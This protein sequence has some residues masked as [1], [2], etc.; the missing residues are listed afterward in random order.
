[1]ATCHIEILPCATKKERIEE[2]AEKAKTQ[3]QKNAT[4]FEKVVPWEF[5]RCQY[6]PEIIHLIASTEDI[7]CGWAV[8]RP[9][10]TAGYSILELDTITTRRKRMGEQRLGKLMFD[11]I[12]DLFQKGGYDF[13][14][15]HGI[16][17]AVLN[18]YKSWGFAPL[19][20]KEDLSFAPTSPPLLKPFLRHL[21][22]YPAS[23]EVKKTFKDK[24][25]D[26]G[27]ELIQNGYLLVEY[28]PNNAK[29]GR[30]KTQRRKR[31]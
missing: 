9:H 31:N 25:I 26:E 3:L 24:M 29:G 8:L 10:E 15:L 6:E 13:L 7:I 19:F 20:S 1:M 23:T 18:I 12:R 28:G 2:L 4:E 14:M 22:I 16:N 5:P 11:A 30:R 17:D 21:M 27:I